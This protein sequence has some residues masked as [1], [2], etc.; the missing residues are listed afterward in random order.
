M[1]KETWDSPLSGN[2]REDAIKLF[3]E[4]VR[5]SKVKF[6]RSLMSSGWKDKPWGVTFSDGSGDAYGGVMYLRWESNQGVEV[7]LVESKAK[8]TPLDQKGDVV[9]AEMCGAVFAAR[10]KGYLQKHRRLEVERWFHFVDSQKVLGAIQR[11]SY[12]YQTFF[13]NRVGEIQKARPVTDWWWIPG[14]LNIADIVTRG[15]TPE[16]LREGSEWQRG[17]QFLVRGR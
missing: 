15:A 13:A 6:H 3:E 10:L 4:Y 11:E 16:D 1:T 17:P 7:R 5:L 14:P 9:K 2:L 12:G 8:L